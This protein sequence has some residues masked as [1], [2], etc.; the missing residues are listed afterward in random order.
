VNSEAP[1][2]VL[3]SIREEAASIVALRRDIHAHPE[4]AYEESR[5]SDLIADT[6]SGWGISV[7]RGLGKTGVIGA[8]QGGTSS[9]A[10]GLRADMD[11]LPITERNTF[12]HVSTYPGK[13]H[14]CG[15]DGHIAMLL[16]AAKYLAR[17]RN[18]DGT[19]YLIFQPA[20]EGAAGARAMIGDGLF[21]RFPMDAIFG[22]HNWPR[23]EA[24]TFAI[25]PGPIFAS[26]S[27]FAIT[28]RGK[29]SHAA[30]PHTGIDPI[31]IACQIVQLLQNVMTRNKGPLEVA[32]ISVTMIH[33]GEAVNAVPDCCEIRGT[34]RTFT[35]AVLDMIEERMNTIA[36]CACASFGANC[37]LEF[38]RY[39]PPTINHPAETAFVQRVLRRV[40]G[41]DK[42]RAFEGT[43]ASEDFGFYLREKSGCYFLI[44]NGY[45]EHRNSEDATG[46]CTLHNPTYDFND[47]LI[48][49]GGAMWVHLVEQWL[50]N[51]RAARESDA[52]M[53]RGRSTRRQ[54]DLP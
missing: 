14:A 28:V 15:H 26:G 52:A 16:A 7:I 53:R 51:A 30:M 18:F 36:Q 32:V 47:E 5:T 48:P 9:R 34:V 54:V 27:R 11:A 33:A 21:R 17:Y 39:Y 35:T 6:L 29:G 23:L 13:M 25:K 40:F 49:I 12:D 42:V 31:P 45:G 3:K 41:K 37:E 24:G 4:L 50:G 46:S 22:M 43:M 10:I 44:G 20:E 1:D 2:A 19:V 38:E 8:I